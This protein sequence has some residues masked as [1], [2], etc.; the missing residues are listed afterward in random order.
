MVSGPAS[1]APYR[2]AGLV[3]DPAAERNV[4]AQEYSFLVML[5]G[6]TGL[7]LEGVE[8]LWSKDPSDPVSWRAYGERLEPRERGYWNSLVLPAMAHLKAV[9]P[10]FEP[11]S[12]RWAS[13]TAPPPLN[14][15]VWGDA[16]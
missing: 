15:F 7:Y 14:F 16:R 6:D 9:Y 10:G 5:F 1:A 13:S 11:P 12:R 4:L 8:E 3:P 2:S